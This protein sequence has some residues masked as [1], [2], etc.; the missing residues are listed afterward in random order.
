MPGTIGSL[1]SL[2]NHLLPFATPGTPL[3][4][5]L[6][7]LVA[8]CTALYYAPQIQEYVQ[9]RLHRTPTQQQNQAAQNEDTRDQHQVNPEPGHR[10]HGHTPEE[11]A[12]PDQGPEH[13]I[14]P[15]PAPDDEIEDAPFPA[16]G[17]PGPANANPD[18][19]IPAARNVGAKKAKSLA[20]KDQRRAYHEF[21][22]SQGEAQ[23]ARDAEGAAEREAEEA[24]EKARRAAVE[25]KLEAKRTR[26]REERRERERREREEEMGR[27][28]RA[29]G[30][31]REEV[32]RRGVCELEGVARRVG[33]G[34]DRS[35]V[36]ALVRASGLLTEARESEDIV[37][38]TEGGWA[39]RVERREMDEVYRM[40]AESSGVGDAD[41]KVTY[42]ELG[43]LLEKVVQNRAK[44][45]A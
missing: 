31:L 11:P 21:M 36:E 27:R 8:L 28:E 23:R 37:M 40:A 10:L 41:G 25:A 24:A 14:P 5:D 29:V 7:H 32:A 42:R 6:L 34:V 33:G 2:I 39:A 12:L 43:S 26:E 1:Q 17:D 13:D 20:R 3:V 16:D 30:I 35:W 38:I 4:Q 9:Q 22:R 44:A 45:A 15:V 18:R 19:A